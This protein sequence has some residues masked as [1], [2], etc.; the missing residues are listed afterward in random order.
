MY[1]KSKQALY[2]MIARTAVY[3]AK[4]EHFESHRGFEPLIARDN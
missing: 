1:S 3:P 2:D 4:A